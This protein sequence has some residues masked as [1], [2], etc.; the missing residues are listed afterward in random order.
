MGLCRLCIAADPYF[1]MPVFLWNTPDWKTGLSWSIKEC[2]K[3]VDG[4]PEPAFVLYVN[5]EDREGYEQFGEQI[6]T[7][8]EKDIPVFLKELGQE[9]SDRGCKYDEWY[10]AHADRF[11]EIAA[12]YIE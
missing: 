6:G 10:A 12:P 4:K 8:L 1:R 7:I 5:G 11:K 2:V 3:K 9:I